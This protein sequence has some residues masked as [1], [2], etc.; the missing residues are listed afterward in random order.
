ML[1]LKASALALLISILSFMPITTSQAANTVEVS[2]ANNC[3]NE[4]GY[5]DVGYAGAAIKVYAPYSVTLIS[6]TLPNVGSANN[7]GS[8][9]ITIYNDNSGTPGTALSGTLTQTAYA[10][11]LVTV[12]GSITIPS[13]GYYWVQI[14]HNSGTDALCFK[15]TVDSTGSAA[16]WSVVTGLKY[17]TA[18]S[19]LIA[20]SWANFVGQYNYALAFTLYSAGPATISL[21]SNQKVATYRS[22]VTLTATT[23]GTGK[24]KFYADGK[25]ISTCKSVTVSVTTATCVWKPTVHKAVNLTAIFTPT[26]GTAVKTNPVQVSVNARTTN[27]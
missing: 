2:T 10:S 5:S 13:A 8:V 19:G 4:W 11:N 26:S 27:R 18:G 17:G 6:G 9:S 14:G 12:G 20:T 24:V 15:S 25:V 3:V 7:S 23:S 16:G 21:V 1:K 22:S